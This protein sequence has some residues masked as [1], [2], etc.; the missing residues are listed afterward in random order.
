MFTLEIYNTG[1]DAYKHSLTMF[2]LKSEAD[3]TKKHLTSRVNMRI[4]LQVPFSV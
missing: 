4:S 2:Y 3:S 1:Q